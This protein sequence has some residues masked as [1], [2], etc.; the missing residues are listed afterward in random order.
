MVVN[1]GKLLRVRLLKMLI[2]SFMMTMFAGYVRMKAL[3]N[4]AIKLTVF[5]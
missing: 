4:S 2:A 5:L 1:M 3:T